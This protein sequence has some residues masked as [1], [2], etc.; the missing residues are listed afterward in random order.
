MKLPSLGRRGG[1][2]VALQFGLLGAI[3]V[4]GVV[5]TDW[6]AP[7]RWGRLSA[8]ALL[9]LLGAVWLGLGLAALGPALTAFPMPRRSASLRS[10]SVYRFARHP[11]YGGL[12]L[13]GLGWSL[14]TSAL[15]LLP[16]AGL[17]LVLE[18]KSRREE[19]WLGEKVPGYAAY[20]AAVRRRFLPWLW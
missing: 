3:L 20:R 11:I 8:A 1:G 13:V 14:G 10:G 19:Q 17:V 12:I 16:W 4:I 18:L 15:C 2:W 6:T 7:W 5:S 9:V